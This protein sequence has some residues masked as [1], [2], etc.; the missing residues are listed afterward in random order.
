M[1]T[2]AEHA[3]IIRQALEFNQTE[4]PSFLKPRKYLAGSKAITF[5]KTT[6]ILPNPQ[7]ENPHTD[8]H[9][10]ISNRP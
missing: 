6:E 5:D 3:A 10:M 1:D 2:V 9:F 7:L 4:T 8:K